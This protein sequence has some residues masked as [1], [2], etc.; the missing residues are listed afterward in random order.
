M[1]VPAAWLSRRLSP[2]AARPVSLN[3][4]EIEQIAALLE[5]TVP[6]LFGIEELIWPRE[7]RSIRPRRGTET[8]GLRPA[9]R[10]VS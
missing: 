1:H 9:L 6:S 7:D 4:D 2:H 3:L 10:L 5:I 8:Y